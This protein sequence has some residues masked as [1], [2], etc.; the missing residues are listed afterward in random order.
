VAVS[1][2]TGAIASP[3]SVIPAAEVFSNAKSWQ[4]ILEDWLPDAFVFGLP[5]SLDGTPH[6]QAEKIKSQAIKIAETANL[7]YFF[8]DERLS[9]TSAKRILQEQGLNQRQMRGKVDKIA[10]SIFLQSFLDA[11]KLKG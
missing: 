11:Q 3:V 6:E 9:S 8:W 2:A 7:P 1:D 4:R 5:L 10:A